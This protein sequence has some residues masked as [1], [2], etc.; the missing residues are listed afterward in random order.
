MNVYS[1]QPSVLLHLT[2]ASDIWCPSLCRQASEHQINYAIFVNLY[3]YENILYGDVSLRGGGAVLNMATLWWHPPVWLSLQ[4]NGSHVI[5]WPI[6]LSK[7]CIGNKWELCYRQLVRNLDTIHFR[8]EVKR[9]KTNFF[10]Q[11]GKAHSDL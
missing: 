6:K 3:L 1:Q 4:Q 5:F 2:F 8:K 10:L 9:G 11:A 7:T